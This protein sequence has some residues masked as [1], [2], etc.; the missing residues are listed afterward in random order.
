MTVFRKELTFSCFSF[1]HFR[2]TL[3]KLIIFVILIL[4]SLLFMI[5]DKDWA[6]LYVCLLNIGWSCLHELLTEDV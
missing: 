3:F 1:I 2:L 6:M 5:G 4:I